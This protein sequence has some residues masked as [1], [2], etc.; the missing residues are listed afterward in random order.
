M[1]VGADQSQVLTH[2]LMTSFFAHLR[3]QTSHRETRTNMLTCDSHPISPVDLHVH[4]LSILI[5]DLH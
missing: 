4:F 1:L 3:P 5:E 2:I